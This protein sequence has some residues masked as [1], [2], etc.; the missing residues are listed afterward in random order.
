MNYESSN[1]KRLSGFTLIEVLI[2]I[3]MIGI[4]VAIALPS[5][6]SFL[7]QGRRAD[8]VVIIQEVAGEQERF[9]SEN[10][11]YS[12]DLTEM[13]YDSAANVLSPDGFYQ[14]T[15]ATPT[16]TSYVLTAVPANPGPQTVDAECA[17]ITLDSGG[18]KT[19]TECW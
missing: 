4:L 11:R 17:T 12:N 6:Q 14:I 5:F 19:P 7:I 1:K 13:G 3:A 9:F 18:V 10:N 2:V 15:A 16:N 8:A